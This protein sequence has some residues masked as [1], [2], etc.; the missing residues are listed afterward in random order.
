MRNAFYGF[1]GAQRGRF[2]LFLPVFMAGGVLLYFARTSEPSLA[3]AGGAALLSAAMVPLAWRWPVLRAVAFCAAFASGGFALACV[4][5]ARAP[6][7]EVLPR[8]AVVVSGRVVL[9]EMLPEGRRVTLATPSLDG[10][11]A[12]G[13]DLRIRLRTSDQA[14]V[15]AGDTI[16]VRA[17]VRLPSPPD[18]PG[19]RD[20]QLDAYFARLAGYGFAIGPAAV[21]PQAGAG[22]SRSSRWWAGLRG[23]IAHRLTAGLPGTP[24]AIAS[25]LLTGMGTSIPPDVRADFQNSGLSHLLAV[26]GLHIG[27]VMGLVFA[28]SRLA[29]AA[30]ERSALHWPTRKMAALAALAAGLFYLA[31][32]GGHVPIL[33]SFAM[34]ALVTLGVLT[35]RR[36]I[37]LRGLCLAATVL[38]LLSPASVVGVS[39]QMSFASVLVLIAGYEMVRPVL[40]RVSPG[41]WWRGP[42]LYLAGLVLTSLLA[43]TASLPFAAY[44]FGRAT[45]YYVP[46][47]MAAVPLT[48]LW[49]MP[50]GLAALALMPVGLEGLALAPMGLGLRGLAWIAHAVAGWPEASVAVPMMPGWG[51]ALVAVGLALAGL[52]RG[53]PRLMGVAPIVLGLAAPLLVRPPDMLVGAEARLIAFRVGGHTLVEQAAGVTPFEASAPGRI[54]GAAV[55]WP[56]QTGPGVTCTD[57]ACR[58]AFPGGQASLARAMGGADCS[59]PVIVSAIWLRG[60]CAGRLVIDRQTA[61][62]NGAAFI[63]MRPGGV[64]VTTDRMERGTRPWVLLTAPGLP[65]AQTE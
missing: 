33:R 21:L 44:H 39:F 48:A 5:S 57:V 40:M 19:G 20:T 45:L 56:V 46:A 8:H 53:W 63:R 22:Q 32:T 35:G 25:T 55:S 54:W 52:W 62:R 41:A 42:V 43:G 1:L 36:A 31:L 34:A 12:L 9:L 27:I 14:P 18:Y 64:E 28:A 7:W 13:R 58:V 60:A 4:Q 26:A 37:S 10:D 11:A 6:P 47:N 24:G 17:L 16:R 38:M 30:W 50:W 49:V 65:L 59:A 15:A 2:A 61:E 51:L 23:T 3:L 29:L